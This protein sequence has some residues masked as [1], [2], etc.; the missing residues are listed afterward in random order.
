[1]SG[2]EWNE[3]KRKS[4]LSKHGVDFAAI[5]SFVWE[6]AKVIEDRRRSYGEA[7]F[8]AF[9]PIGRRLHCV[10][11]SVRGENIRIISLRKAN[12]REVAIYGQ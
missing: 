4:N 11:F 7:R 3:T 1:M 12:R 5:D 2:Y 9:G 8:L 10:V 6:A